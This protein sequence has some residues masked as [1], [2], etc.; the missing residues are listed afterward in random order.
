MEEGSLLTEALRYMEQQRMDASSSLDGAGGDEDQEQNVLVMSLYVLMDPEE[1]DANRT[2]V[3]QEE[4]ATRVAQVGRWANAIWHGTYAQKQCLPYPWLGGGDGPVFGAAC[5]EF[6]MLHLKATCGYGNSVLDEWVAVAFCMQLTVDLFV[7][8]N[9]RV[10][11][12][13][14]DKDD[15]AHLLLIEAANVLPAWVDDE[16]RPDDTSSKSDPSRER[17]WVVNGLVTLLPPQSPSPAHPQQRLGQSH[18]IPVLTRSSALDILANASERLFHDQSLDT[19]EQLFSHEGSLLQVP[20]AVQDVIHERVG[21]FRL[22]LQRQQNTKQLISNPLTNIRHHFHK[23]AIVLPRALALVLQ[24]RPDWIAPSVKSFC[25]YGPAYMQHVSSSSMVQ[26]KTPKTTTTTTTAA[27]SATDTQLWDA[28][29]QVIDPH[30][31]V[32]TTIDVTRT[33]HAMLLTGC[34]KVS[35]FP[36]P[37]PFQSVELNRTRRQL[38]MD[39]LPQFRHAFDAGMRLFAGFEWFATRQKFLKEPNA[40]TPGM[41]HKEERV[42]VHWSTLIHQTREGTEEDREW[43]E[44]TWLAGPQQKHEN[45]VDM[46]ALMECPVHHAEIANSNNLSPWTHPGTSLHSQINTS[47]KAMQKKDSQNHHTF[48]MPR[49]DDVDGDEWLELDSVDAFDKMMQNVTQS[50]GDRRSVD[51]PNGTM[52]QDEKQNDRNVNGEHQQKDQTTTSLDDMVEGMHTFIKG[53]SSIEGVTSASTISSNSTP[54]PLSPRL[55]Y[56]MLDVNPVVFVNMLDKVLKS[57][58]DAPLS[59]A[60][61]PVADQDKYFSKGDYDF[62]D[63]S[64]DDDDDDDDDEEGTHEEGQYQNPSSL[65]H[66]MTAMDEEVGEY[67]NKSDVDPELSTKIDMLSNFLESLEAEGGGSGPVSNMLKEMGIEP[68]EL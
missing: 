38:R 12:Q 4:R 49:T 37:K 68:P 59:F 5:D 54:A 45:G 64:D 36:I 58:P 27:T 17:C 24:D 39:H 65:K 62:A 67:R 57:P 28:L 55:E 53:K 47:I 9:A 60:S 18:K 46:E 44:R 43:I 15:H 14:W 21:P 6:G 56:D 32:V 48:V 7:Q 20:R 66:I 25:S 3:S 26:K 33:M 8:H 51:H 63:D 16:C 40:S 1:D 11:L 22:A 61:S 41:T 52:D 35:D 13:C 2:T 42:R 50:T 23:A 29:G 10:A 19:V 31:W 30:D 34:G